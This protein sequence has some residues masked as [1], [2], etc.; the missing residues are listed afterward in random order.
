MADA[1][2]LAAW[3]APGAAAEALDA[4]AHA[5]RVPWLPIVAEHPLLRVGPAVVP[6][7]GACRRCFE[8]RRRQ[9]AAAPELTDALADHYRA[10]PDAGPRGFLPSHA[11]IAAALGREALDG[12]AADPDAEA[13][14]YRQFHVVSQRLGAGRAVGLH[15]C[16]RCGSGRDERTRSYAE[17]VRELAGVLA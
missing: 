11:T 1:Y 12:L 2:V 15:G 14:R 5:W 6:G 7:R 8:A 13:G 17:L 9:H 3:R 4:L 16:P 10:H